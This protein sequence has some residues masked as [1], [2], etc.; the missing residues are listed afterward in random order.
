MQPLTEELEHRAFMLLE[1]P[2]G[3]WY[4]EMPPPNGIIFVE[5][6]GNK[7]VS[8]QPGLMKIVGRL[9]LN[10][11]D[12]EDFIFQIRQAQVSQPD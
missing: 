7:A 3:C 8:W 11:K 12:P 5:L 10:D 1:Y 6:A 9:R 2:V 4:C